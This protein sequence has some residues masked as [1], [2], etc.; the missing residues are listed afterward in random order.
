MEMDQD[1]RA[2]YVLMFGLEQKREK[3]QKQ[4]VRVDV[5]AYY[6]LLSSFSFSLS[7]THSLS[8]LENS[9]PPLDQLEYGTP[10]HNNRR[11]T[12]LA[13]A[14]SCEHRNGDAFAMDDVSCS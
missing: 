8:S 4:G 3:V 14:M 9:S 12:V 2:C 1:F 10:L 13:V 7:L 5:S 6:T 11:S